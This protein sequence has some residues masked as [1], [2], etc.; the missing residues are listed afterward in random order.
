M[1]KDVFSEQA[2][3]PC[4]IPLFLEEFMKAIDELSE[5][6]QSLEDSGESG[7]LDDLVIDLKCAEASA[8]NNEGISGQVEYVVEQ[9]GI[10]EALKQLRAFVQ[11]LRSS[12]ER[13]EGES[14]DALS[15]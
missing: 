7:V 11:G 6:I 5:L 4:R 14:A 9:L 15:P 12:S 13:E 10:E 2:I 8:I 1:E 3:F